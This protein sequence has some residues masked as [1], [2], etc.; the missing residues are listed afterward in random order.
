MVYD[1]V[2]PFGIFQEYSKSLLVD[3]LSEHFIKKNVVISFDN[4]EFYNE[5]RNYTSKIIQCSEIS[6][7]GEQSLQFYFIKPSA[8]K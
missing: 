4:D 6:F 8:F 7:Q 2:V 5:N 3:D 1:E